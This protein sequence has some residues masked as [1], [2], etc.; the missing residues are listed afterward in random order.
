MEVGQAHLLIVGKPFD[1]QGHAAVE[2]MP[3]PSPDG[4]LL[5]SV[6]VQ[7]GDGDS[8][9]VNGQWYLSNADGTDSTPLPKMTLESLP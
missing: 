6:Q 2:C 9:T 1:Q 3:R 4:K 8:D 5:L 7:G